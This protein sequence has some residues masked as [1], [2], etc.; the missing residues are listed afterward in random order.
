MQANVLL[1]IMKDDKVLLLRRALSMKSDKKGYYHLVGGKVEEGE[2]FTQAAMREAFEE[3][4]IEFASDDLEFFNVTHELM[5]LPN[6]EQ[7]KEFVTIT[8][9]VKKWHGQIH[10][11]E[12]HKHDVFEWY[13][14]DALPQPL[15]ATEKNLFS[16][17]ARKEGYSEIQWAPHK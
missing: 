4:G 8:F 5:K 17:I 3:V 9:L 11:K 13:S 14:L 1:L 10:N 6:Q 12:M 16:I 15:F 7:A 2:T